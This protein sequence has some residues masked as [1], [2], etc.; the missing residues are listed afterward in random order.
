[1]TVSESGTHIIGFSQKDERCYP[2]ECGYMYQSA[3]FIVVKPNNGSDLNGG[4]EFLECGKSSGKIQF[5]RDFYAEIKNLQKGT[6]FI[7]ADV[8]IDQRWQGNPPFFVN[9]YG[10][11]K[12]T[13]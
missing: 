6:Y 10:P 8:D 11:G 5:E 9:N 3:R 1:M 13:F 12:T 4:F 7:L 2:R